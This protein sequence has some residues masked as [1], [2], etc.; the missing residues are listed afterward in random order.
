MY[1]PTS[2]G[3]TAFVRWRQ[4]RNAAQA[5]TAGARRAAT[6]YDATGPTAQV[7]GAKRIAGPAFAF[8]QV[9]FSPSGAQ[10]ACV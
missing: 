9:R 2:D 6:L 8:V 4:S 3:Q 7:S 10:T 5:E 1:P